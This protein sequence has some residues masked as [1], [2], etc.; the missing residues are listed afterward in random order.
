MN[1]QEI[2]FK[3]EWEISKSDITIH[4]KLGE[5]SFGTVMKGVW[6]GTTVA[7]KIINGPSVNLSE[8][9][10]EMEILSKIHHPNILQFLGACTIDN[11]YMIVMEYMSN[12]SLQSK[13]RWMSECRKIEVMKDISRGLAYLHNRKP[14][15]IIH[16]D[17]KPSNILLTNSYRAKIADFGI[18]CVRPRS[19]ESYNMTGETGTYRYMAPEVLTYKPYSAKVDIWSFG[20]II[21]FMFC[22]EPFAGYSINQI[23]NLNLK[24]N[25]ILMSP[26]T[27]TTVEYIF[28]NSTKYN[29]DER[30]DS[31]ILV[32]HCNLVNC[33]EVSKSNNSCCLNFRKFLKR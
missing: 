19:N 11:P 8:F 4:Q 21:Y 33:E 32:Q 7:L 18:S 17:L 25:E 10:M 6:R 22:G 27:P 26:N 29:P 14:E 24:S 15:C 28:R 9:T 2:S 30:W 23:L 20:M 3:G 1:I 16:R 5:G 12:D 13:I 31:L